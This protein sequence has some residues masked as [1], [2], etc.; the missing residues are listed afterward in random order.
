[1]ATTLAPR[2]T[3][4]PSSLASS[5]PID[6]LRASW[7]GRAAGCGGTGAPCCVVSDVRSP[8]PAGEWADAFVADVAAAAIAT[9][10]TTTQIRL[11][12]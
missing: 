3:A 2:C 5:H 1:M 12:T 10:T 6:A 8:E 9:T 4:R 7:G 11:K